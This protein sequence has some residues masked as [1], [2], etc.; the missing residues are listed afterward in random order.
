M[1]TGSLCSC[2]Q[3]YLLQLTSHLQMYSLYLRERILRL[4]QSGLRPAALVKTLKKEGF[5][6]SRSGIYY[7]I[8]KYSNTGMIYDLPRSGRPKALSENSHQQIDKWLQENNELTTTNILNSLISQGARISRSSVGRAIQRLGWSGKTTR[9][10]QL[11]R[12]A[13]KQKRMDFCQHMLSTRE[14]FYDII[15]TDETLVQLKPTHRKSYHKKGQQRRF[16]PKPKHPVKVNVWGGISSRGATDVVIFTGIMDAQLYTRILSTALIPFMNKHPTVSFRFQQDNDPKHTSRVAR[17]FF[18]THGVNWWKTPAESPDLNPIE[19]VW[20]HLKLYLTY[21]VKP[22][23]KSELVEGIKEFWKTK[24]TISQCRRYINHLHKVLPVI[25][26]K[27]G[28]AVVDDEI[29]R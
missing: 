13:N 8:K 12:E 3:T 1:T 25:I 10:C 21:H 24:L 28:H 26:A 15:F 20:H 18:T 6:V 9:Y 17:D 4:H 11:I 27:D 19:R 14:N 16:R 7:V 2:P 5:K 22:R 23:N 29:P